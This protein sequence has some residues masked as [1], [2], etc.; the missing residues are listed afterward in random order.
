MVGG[1]STVLTDRARIASNGVLETIAR[2]LDRIGLTPNGVTVIGSS[3][4]VIVAWL[5]A[6]GHPV[7][8]GLALA[9]VA[10]FD[11]VDGT[12]ARMTG[13][14]SD[15]GSFLD[16]TLDRVSE[17]I[18]FVGLYLYFG[19]DATLLEEIAILGALTGS[20]MVSYT[21]ARSEGIGLGTSVGIFDRL[22][23]TGV[24]VLALI[25]MQVFVGVVIVAIGAW[26]TATMRVLDVARRSAS[27]RDLS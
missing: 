15:F 20:L 19:R 17:V 26:S 5:L 12:L 23:R 6:E 1:K 24:I 4:H 18:L 22:V 14:V 9:L 8:A 2:R 13:R 25:T 27:T 3:S 11:A 7:V 10:S 16:S 21:R